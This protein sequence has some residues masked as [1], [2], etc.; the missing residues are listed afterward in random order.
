MR[1]S[2]RPAGQ[3]VGQVLGEL[4][5]KVMEQVW[6]KPGCTARDVLEGLRP[7]RLAYTTVVTI[8]DRLFQKGLVSRH[9]EG[10][11][12]VYQAAISKERFDEDLTR[13]V[14][15]GLFKENSRP[16]VNAFVDLVST[17]EDLLS[18]LEEL[19]RDKAR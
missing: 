11:P 18:E 19:I 13:E 9:R 15:R 3:G 17:D 12:F 14:L 16:V 6:A 5:T 8:L 1:L 7:R 10:K 2:F 4:E